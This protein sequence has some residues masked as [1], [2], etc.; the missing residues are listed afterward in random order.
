M[1]RIIFVGTVKKT[2][3]QKYIFTSYM[4]VFLI[5]FLAFEPLFK[6]ETSVWEPELEPG[7]GPF[8]N[9]PEPVIVIAVNNDYM[10]PE[11]KI[12]LE[13]TGARAQAG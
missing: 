10:E 2:F 3:I 1:F 8:K 12:Y 4:I 5:I 6:W 11:P 13:S 9:K 7:A